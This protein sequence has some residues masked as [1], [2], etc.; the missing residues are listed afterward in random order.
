MVSLHVIS[1]RLGPK[2]DFGKL[3]FMFFGFGGSFL[4]F[5]LYIAGF[6]Q[7]LCVHVCG[8]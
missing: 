4:M 2:L 1:V 6:L 3:T 7:L 8:A 5:F